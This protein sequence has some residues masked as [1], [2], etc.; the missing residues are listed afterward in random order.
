MP[1]LEYIRTSFNLILVFIPFFSLGQSNYQF[2][3][4]SQLTAPLG[5]QNILAFNQGLIHLDN[6]Y[7]PSS[8]FKE[9]KVWGKLGGIAYRAT[10]IFLIHYPLSHT[11]SLYH[12]ELFGHVARA[13]QIGFTNTRIEVNLPP[14]FMSGKGV[15]YWSDLNSPISDQAGLMPYLGGVEAN[16]VLADISRVQMLQKDYIPYQSFF[17]PLRTTT[18]LLF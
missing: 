16:N 5:A 4:E 8:F 10:K 11:L 1:S 2:F 6:Q 17:L 7:I 13:R 9:K 14:P 15:A 3:Y 18:C 12:H